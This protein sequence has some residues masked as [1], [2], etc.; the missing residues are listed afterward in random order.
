MLAHGL[1]SRSSETEAKG[2]RWRASFAADDG[3]DGDGAGGGGGSGGE[4]GTNER[5]LC[6]RW[7]FGDVCD[8]FRLFGATDFTVGVWPSLH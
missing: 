3:I 4:E 1:E 2:R 8:V 5:R 6:W 7:R